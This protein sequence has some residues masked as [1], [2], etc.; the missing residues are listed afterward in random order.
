M[1]GQTKRGKIT[2]WLAALLVMLVA[3]G[4]IGWRTAERHSFVGKNIPVRP[5]RGT[6]PA[7]YVQHIASAEESAR[8]YFQSVA[9]LATLS[10]LYHANGFYREAIQCYLALQ[11]L[12]PRHARW[13]HL[14]A[15]ILAGFG[16]IDEA[17]PLWRQAIALAPDYIPA[18]LRLGDIF[19]KS[20]RTTDAIRIYTEAL[21]HDPA[22]PYALLGLARGAIVE[23]EWLKARGFLQTAIKT[24]PDFIG[25]LSLL[26][27]V[28]EHLGESNEA[29]GLQLVIGR[30]EYSDTADPWL[31]ELTEDC[32]DSYRLSVAAA[33]AKAAGNQ[34]TARHFLERA[35][36][37]SPEAG[38]YRRQ[39][40]QI[41]FQNKEYIPARQQL[42]KAVAVAPEDS[43][44]WL[45]LVDILT[46][47]GAP[48]EAERALAAGLAACPQSAALHYAY[49]H[50]LSAARRYSEAITELQLS[51]K[52]RP[53]EA[54]A[55]VDLALVYFGL[56][57]IEEG[58]AEM[59]GALVVQPGN[60]LALQVLARHSINSGDEPAARQLIRR[61]HQQPRVTEADMR[62]I[63]QE[64]Q[65]RFGQAPW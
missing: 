15:S 50:R 52:L 4:W 21:V 48:A 64:Y 40:G 53:S 49:G 2:G 25:A 27:T 1:T 55:Y 23:G 57:R 11:R 14:H 8:S 32:Y 38:S 45:L 30:R 61:L 10:R 7:E 16:Q 9:G 19:T 62:T 24:N 35:V 46:D 54:Y 58:I 51:K 13:F 65:A 17:I 36:A 31:D 28:Y 18:R 39:L 6:W 26:V 34:A 44:A 56:E 59:K 42:E 33:V 63:S 43:D 41:Y 20:N 29:R 5:A 60:P 12:E 37:Q 47:M 22:N 3:A